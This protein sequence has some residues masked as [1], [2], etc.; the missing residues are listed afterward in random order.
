MLQS[1]RAAERSYEPVAWFYDR[2][3]ALYS[4]GQI[5]AAKR[6]QVA[7]MAS[8]D[9]VLC[10]GVGGG[11]EVAS[12]ARAGVALTC[13]DLAPS[14]LRRV[15]TR[16]ASDGL[17]AELI[18]GDI[19]RHD[20]LGYYDIVTANFFLNI[21]DESEM[22]EMLG[23]LAR[24]VRPGGKVLIAD[25][26]PAE[27]SWLTRAAHEAHYQLGLTAFWLLGL[28]PRHPIY[29]YRQYFAGAGLTLAGRRRF[30]LGPAS[31]VSLTAERTQRD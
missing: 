11:E 18:R 25:F 23:H 9:R 21:F 12:A 31:F 24:L 5:A 27:G 20:R 13:V 10:V 19:R 6:S 16:L 28:T 8:G 26:A 3:A 17:S 15:A 29:D 1:S 2:A 4:A 7:L 14:M 22:V 30:R